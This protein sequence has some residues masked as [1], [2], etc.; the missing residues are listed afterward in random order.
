MITVAKNFLKHLN[1]AF[2]SES[3]FLKSDLFFSYTTC[4]ILID[5]F[6]RCTSKPSVESKRISTWQKATDGG[7]STFGQ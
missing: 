2:I 6:T 4:P 7:K 1:F 5:M 3:D